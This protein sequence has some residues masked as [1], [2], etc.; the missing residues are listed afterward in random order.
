VLVVACDGNENHLYFATEVLFE[1][2][3]NFTAENKSAMD[4][5]LAQ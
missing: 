5:S 4:A 1:K 3:L 2:L